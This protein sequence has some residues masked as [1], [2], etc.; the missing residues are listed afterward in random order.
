MRK[1]LVTKMATVIVGSALLITGLGQG[2]SKWSLVD[3][4]SESGSAAPASLVAD[5]PSIAAN[6]LS[7]GLVYGKQILDNFTGCLGSGIPS[8]RTLNVYEAKQGSISEDGA[9]GTVTAPMLMAT[10]SIAGEVCMDLINQERG[11][12]LNA[13]RI[14]TGIDFASNSVPA[15]GLMQDAARRIARSC[16]D[17]DEESAEADVIL[18]SVNSAFSSAP[19]AAVATPVAQDAM[20]FL[21]TSMMS[22]LE[23][24][25]L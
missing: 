12:S 6:T 13:R 3:L 15:Q 20:L 1:S 18:Q 10:A 17:R 11:L 23:A 9:V 14:F 22:S 2:C 25:A 7:I 4:N 21:C 8:Q 19:T 5:D 16:W 24:I